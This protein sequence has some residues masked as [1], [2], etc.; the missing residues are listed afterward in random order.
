MAWHLS[1]VTP[2]L[3]KNMCITTFVCIMPMTHTS[4]T[5]LLEHNQLMQY[6]PNNLPWLDHQGSK[7]TTIFKVNFLFKNQLTCSLNNTILEEQ[8]FIS[9]IFLITSIFE[10]L[11]FLKMSPIFVD[12]YYVKDKPRV[13]IRLV[14]CT[15]LK[16]KLLVYHCAF[17][18]S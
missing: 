16:K 7:I 14:E 1:F 10:I 11:Y 13:T 3:Q 4:I 2:F 5:T 8:L 17:F 9:D 6:F 18:T 15:K 12:S